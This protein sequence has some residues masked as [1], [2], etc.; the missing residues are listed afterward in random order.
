[1]YIKYSTIVDRFS[2]FGGSVSFFSCA[3]ILSTSVYRISFLTSFAD[4]W[5]SYCCFCFGSHT[6]LVALGSITSIYF[7]ALLT[8]SFVFLSMQ[9]SSTT[10]SR[11][12]G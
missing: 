12:L 5:V 6:P 7:P 9:R 11:K 8:L 2:A 10:F 4:G 3:K 1:M